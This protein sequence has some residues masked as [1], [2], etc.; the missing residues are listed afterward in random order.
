MTHLRGLLASLVAL[1]LIALLASAVHAEAKE[2]KPT[3]QWTGSVEDEKLQKE[4][5]TVIA[6]AKTFEKVWKAWKPADKVPEV[7]FAKELVLVATTRGSRLSIRLLL[8]DSGNLKVGAIA[9]RDLRPGFRYEM[10]VVPREG[11]KT[12]DGKEIP[13]E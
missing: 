3:K 10:V 13:K 8:E 4:A 7:D 6:S 11:I 1:G 9:T 2:V 5:P 12:V